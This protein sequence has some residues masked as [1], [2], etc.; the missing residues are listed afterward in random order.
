[1]ITSIALCN[2]LLFQITE[3]SL[4]TDVNAHHVLDF[5]RF[6]TIFLWH[7]CVLCIFQCSKSSVS[8]GRHDALDLHNK[9]KI[10]V[11]HRSSESEMRRK[12]CRKTQDNST[13]STTRASKSLITSMCRSI[14]SQFLSSASREMGK[15]SFSVSTT[16]YHRRWTHIQ[17]QIPSS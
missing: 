10:C 12:T 4:R 16:Q 7:L 11:A 2:F 14:Q 3:K 13:S 5:S 9:K 17:S 8:G 1:M 6:N 15:E